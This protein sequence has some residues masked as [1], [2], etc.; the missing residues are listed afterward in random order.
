M[1]VDYLMWRDG[2]RRCRACDVKVSGVS[3]VGS[4]RS[5]FSKIIQT[6]SYETVLTRLEAKGGASPR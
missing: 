2:A 3:L 5:E 1:L 6:A 4:Y